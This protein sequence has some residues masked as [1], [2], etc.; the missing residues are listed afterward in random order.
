MPIG[1]SLTT[2]LLRMLGAGNGARMFIRNAG[3]SLPVDTE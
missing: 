3:N 1:K 2:I